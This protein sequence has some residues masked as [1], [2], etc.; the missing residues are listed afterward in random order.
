[1]TSLYN[2]K[3]SGD[4]YRISKFNSDFDVE[5]SYLC[6][7]TACEC[8]AG[9][10]PTCRH[11]EMLPKFIAREAVGTS[12]FYDHDRGGWVQGWKEEPSVAS[13]AL[14]LQQDDPLQDHV[15]T[16]ID[17]IEANT[18]TFLEELFAAQPLL[19]Q[20]EQIPSQIESPNPL[21][22]SVAEFSGVVT[23]TVGN[24]NEGSIPY[25]SPLSASGPSSS[26]TIRRR[27]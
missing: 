27:V 18:K 22:E 8:P 5:A 6:N 24:E 25:A 7:E 1:M 17:E 2:C 16:L 12:W 26:P 13:A 21:A 19:D 10:R 4:Q 11:R 9:H 3:H 23:P 20:P 15:N 14:P